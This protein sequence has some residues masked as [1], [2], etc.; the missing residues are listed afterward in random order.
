M[1][2][3]ISFLWELAHNSR[4]DLSFRAKTCNLLGLLVIFGG[5][6]TSFI[7]HWF[8]SFIAKRGECVFDVNNNTN[9]IIFHISWAYI[10][11][12]DYFSFLLFYFRFFIYWI[13]CRGFCAEIFTSLDVSYLEYHSYFSSTKHSFK[14]FSYLFLNYFS[15]KIFPLKYIFPLT[16]SFLKGFQIRL[17]PPLQKSRHRN[18]CERIWN[19]Q[20]T[21]ILGA[22]RHPFK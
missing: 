8:S 22:I 5:I 2:F 1:L 19:D 6:S 7:L 13:S 18:E 3:I 11:D 4:E 20:V 12:P 10:L 9:R 14:E 15:S 21:S 17:C 16:F